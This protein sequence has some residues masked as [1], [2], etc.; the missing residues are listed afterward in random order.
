M[1]RL[2]YS[3]VCFAALFASAE[4]AAAQTY[5][6]RYPVC[7][8]VAE[9]FGGVRIDCRFTSMAQCAATASGLGGTCY[10]NPYWGWKNTSQ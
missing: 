5:N 10:A 2:A 8:S 9:T 3:V 7:I 1:H 6:P 4:P